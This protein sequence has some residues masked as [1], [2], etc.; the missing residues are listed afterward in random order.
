MKEILVF[1]IV[2]WINYLLIEFPLRRNSIFD[3]R[4][5]NLAADKLRA[6]GWDA[7]YGMKEM[8]QRLCEAF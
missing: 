4:K 2:S 3:I 5:M 6:L 7:H 8:V 1:L